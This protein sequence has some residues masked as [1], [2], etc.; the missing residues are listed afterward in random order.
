MQIISRLRDRTNDQGMKSQSFDLPLQVISNLVIRVIGLAFTVFE[1]VTY[2]ANPAGLELLRTQFINFAD[3]VRYTPSRSHVV[4][5]KL[6]WSHWIHLKDRGWSKPVSLIGLLNLRKYVHWSRVRWFQG[7]IDRYYGLK[8][9]YTQ[10]MILCLRY[11][12]N[13]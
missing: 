12:R 8:L 2:D 9:K 1:Q 7:M 3:P 6:K 11:Y 4:R 10:D 5:R 13:L